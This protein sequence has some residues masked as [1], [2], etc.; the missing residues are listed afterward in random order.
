M[1]PVVRGGGI[2]RGGAALFFQK[3]AR[4]ILP[5]YYAAFAF[6]LLLDV[7]LIGRRTGGFWDVTLPL[8]GKSI[9]IH[10]LLL[11]NFF[12][13]EAHKIN[14]V[15]W[16]I[17][18]EWWIY[19]LFPGLVWA[20]KFGAG[21]T[22]LG[23]VLGTG[24]LCG[25]C[26]HVFHDIFTLHYIALFVFGM[27]GSE[28][29]GAH[30]PAIRSLR[31]RFPWG[32]LFSAFAGLAALTMTGKIHHFSSGYLTDLLVGLAAM[33]LLIVMSIRPSNPISRG[34]SPKFLVFVGSFS[35]SLYLVHAPLIQVIWQ[36]GVKPLDLAAVPS[37]LLLEL[38][39]VPFIVAAAY[40]FHLVF[41]R[42]FMTKPG[43]KIRTEAQAE[44]A[45][46]ANPA[47]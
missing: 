19:F 8:T 44:A 30:Q 6:S 17:S 1:L 24:L 18:L 34:L 4:R 36:Y 2:L 5:P 43:V 7:T 13:D 16:S 42:P 35:Y 22:A 28:I 9:V 25:I 11:Q 47:P 23:T 12:A 29:A 33:C 40:L 41:E 31:D 27:L 15:F 26:S 10:L 32:A 21:R 38:L 3:R 46:I 39:G 37:F 20:W 14:H 45:A